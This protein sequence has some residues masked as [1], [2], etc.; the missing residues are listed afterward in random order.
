MV[1]FQAKPC[2]ILRLNLFLDVVTEQN[3]EQQAFYLFL[4]ND[5][6]LDE[7]LF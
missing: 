7:F 3:T 2:Y 6:N 4:Y 5:G 1:G